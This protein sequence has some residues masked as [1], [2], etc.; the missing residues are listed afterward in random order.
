MPFAELEDRLS[1]LAGAM[2]STG[3]RPKDRVA[4]FSRNRRELVEVVLACLRQAVVPVPINAL[5]SAQ[6]VEYLIQDSGSRW[7]F[8]DSDLDL[9]VHVER[10]V[11]FGDAYERVIF[12]A[13]PVHLASHA[14]GRPMHYTSGTTGVPKG[15]WV[16]PF[17]ESEAAARSE[18]FQQQ[19]GLV[20]DDIHL[21]CSPLG[22][23]APLRYTIRTLEAGGT[24]VVQERFDAEATLAAIELLSVTT[25]FMVPTHLERILALRAERRFDLSSMR[26]LAHAGAPIGRNTKRAIMEMFPRESVWEFYGSTEGSAT[27]ISSEE[28]LRKQGSVGTPRPGARIVIRG[29]DG[30]KLPSGDVGEI[31]IED[32]SAERF[33]YWGDRPKTKGAWRGDSFT[34]GDLG[35]LDEDDYLFLSGR[36]HDVIITGGVNVYPQEVENVLAQ[37]PAVDE[38]VVYGVES[39]E[40][41]QEVRAAVIPN[42]GHPLAPDL[43]LAWAKEKMASYKCPK[44]IDLVEDLPRTPTGKL[45]RERPVGL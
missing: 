16:E 24:V 15:V 19:W 33:E 14:L 1:R 27:R 28:W 29:E 20:P 10:L 42:E 21:V 2:K 36:K 22:H 45:K 39:P 7:L 26:M 18:D 41:G 35:W 9:S 11:T 6:E 25:T 3:V 31:W 34:V 23:S 40:W 44:R 8:T 5:S 32:P 17:R 30:Q 37:H 4:V 43:L 38:V 13:T 12:E